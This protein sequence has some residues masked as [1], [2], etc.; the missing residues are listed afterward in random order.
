MSTV[1]NFLK[2]YYPDKTI[3]L[4]IEYAI[5]QQV[6]LYF[7]NRLTCVPQPLTM[8]QLAGIKKF[9]GVTILLETGQTYQI[10]LM[11][12]QTKKGTY[13]EVRLADLIVDEKILNKIK[14]EFG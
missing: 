7:L 9:G 14:K 10:G 5:D 2:N 1:I 12:E 8:V 3:N 4:I 13:Q 6:E 11:M